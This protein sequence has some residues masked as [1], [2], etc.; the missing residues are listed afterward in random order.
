MK[1]LMI[2]PLSFMTIGSG[3]TS[4]PIGTSLSKD[5]KNPTTS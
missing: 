3:T 4:K 5:R 1:I 2:G